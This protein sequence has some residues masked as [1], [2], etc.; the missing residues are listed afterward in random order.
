MPKVFDRIKESS[1]STGSGDFI[2][3]GAPT[4]YRTFDSVFS[5]GDQTF[6]CIIAGTGEFEVGQGTYTATNTLERTNVL[7]STSSGNLVNF[8]A[9]SKDVFVTMP[10]SKAATSDTAIAYAIALG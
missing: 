7:S 6:Y 1:T 9:G 3:E 4:G 5:I 10:A 2:L 8:V